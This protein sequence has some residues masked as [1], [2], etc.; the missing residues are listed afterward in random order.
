MEPLTL[1][2][3]VLDSLVDDHE[4][5]ETMHVIGEAAPSGSG[6]VDEADVIAAL[7]DL[8]DRGLV[9]VLEE[10]ADAEVPLSSPSRD[11]AS[12]RRHWFT[13]TAQGWQALRD[14]ADVLDAY[15]SAHGT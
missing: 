13:P 9:Q 3:L 7:N 5:V 6:L 12:M 2:L 11:P 1:E 14:G 10:R 15:W 4:T 8:L